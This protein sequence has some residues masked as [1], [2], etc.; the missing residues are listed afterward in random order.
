[1]LGDCP[2]AIALLESQPSNSVIWGSINRIINYRNEI[3]DSV[4]VTAKDLFSQGGGRSRLTPW[5]RDNF[6]AVSSRLAALL[7]PPDAVNPVTVSFDEIWVNGDQQ[8]YDLTLQSVPLGK[9]SRTG[10]SGI[11]AGFVILY[12][13]WFDKL[14]TG[15]GLSSRPLR[16]RWIL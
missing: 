16:S 9:H 2:H 3:G 7:D 11:T 1:M 6:D 10:S 15:S 14:K 4:A 5:G 13:H 12:R 8:S